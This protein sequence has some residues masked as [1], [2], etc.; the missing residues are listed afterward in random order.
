[1]FFEPVKYWQHEIIIILNDNNPPKEALE[2]AK[3]LLN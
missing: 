2:N 3:R 1:M